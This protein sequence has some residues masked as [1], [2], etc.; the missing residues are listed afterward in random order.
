MSLSMW[1][2]VW[3]LPFDLINEEAGMDIGYGIGTVVEVDYKA[4]ASDQAYF[5]RIQVEIPL[6]KPL[7]RGSQIVS[8]EEDRVKVEYKYERL[9]VLCFQCGRVGHEA[10]NYPYPY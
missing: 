2:Q 10:N 3:G 8:L 9:V 7:R 5:L 1:V 6:N 4:L